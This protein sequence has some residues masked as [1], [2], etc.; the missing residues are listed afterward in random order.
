MSTTSDEEQNIL[1]FLEEEQEEFN[2]IP[3]VTCAE[4]ANNGVLKM[5]VNNIDELWMHNEFEPNDPYSPCFRLI[6]K[7]ID[8]KCNI[9]DA[10]DETEWDEIIVLVG[11]I[12]DDGSFYLLMEVQLDSYNLMFRVQ[13]HDKKA[14]KW[15]NKTKQFIINVPSFLLNIK[16]EKGEWVDFRKIG[17]YHP[18][19]AQIIDILDND[20]FKLKY[21]EYN[22]EDEWKEKDIIVHLSR[23]YKQS[24]DNQFVTRIH[25]PHSLEN[26]LLLRR[27]DQ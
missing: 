16:Y 15:M 7:C 26:D 2:F 25:S 12:E 9:D 17:E 14:D 10:A 6:C 5:S 4:S 20:M 18:R 11:N 13:A 24:I 8:S 22:D 3:D 23:L 21:D 19:L 27:S 1:D